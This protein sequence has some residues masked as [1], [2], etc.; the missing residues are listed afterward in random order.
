MR[1]ERARRQQ[2][3]NEGERGNTTVSEILEKNP[4]LEG[5]GQ[6]EFGWADPDAAGEHAQRLSLIHI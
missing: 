6:Y 2:P 5:L 3:L 4:E 1:S